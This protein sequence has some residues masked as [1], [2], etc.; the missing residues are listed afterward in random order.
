[1]ALLLLCYSSNGAVLL[2]LSFSFSFSFLFLFSFSFLVPIL[3]LLSFSFPKNREYLGLD[4]DSHGHW[5]KPFSFIQIT[6]PQLGIVQAEGPSG[7]ALWEVHGTWETLSG[8][9]AALLFCYLTELI[10]RLLCDISSSNLP[11]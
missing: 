8:G 1:M 6:D 3:L 11:A 4:W 7:G 5:N 10:R 9:F 2:L